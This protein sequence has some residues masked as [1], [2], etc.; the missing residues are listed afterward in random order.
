MTKSDPVFSASSWSTGTAST[1]QLRR[2][3]SVLGCGPLSSGYRSKP[4]PWFSNLNRKSRR[5]PF[6]G[7]HGV[8]WKQSAP[9]TIVLL[10]H[11]GLDAKLEE[12]RKVLLASMYVLVGRLVWSETTE[13]VRAN[14]NGFVWKAWATGRITM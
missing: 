1:G 14:L 6:R 2:T 8:S 7:L 11:C 3:L 13:I 10:A 4:S 5:S 12:C 9:T